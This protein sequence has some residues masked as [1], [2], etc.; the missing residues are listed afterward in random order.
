MS[1]LTSQQR[2]LCYLGGIVL[3]LI[4][5]I[6][7]GM[8]AGETDPGTGRAV[9][10]GT[11]ARL[12]QEYD[13]GDTSLGNVDPAS[14]TMT[15]VLLG[16]RGLA[17]NAL[18]LESMEHQKMKDWAQLRANVDSIVMLQPHF[19]NVWT[20]QSWNLAY[21][22]SVEWDDPRDRYYW[23]KEGAKFSMKGVD[24]NRNYS[25]LYW[26][27]GRIL[28]HKI[29]RADEKRQ[30]R[31]YFRSD[32]DE[33]FEGG[34]DPAVSRFNNREYEDHYLAAKFWYLLANEVELDHGQSLQARVLFRHYP[35]RAAMSY[36]AALQEEGNFGEKT[37]EAWAEA[38]RN[39][40]ESYEGGTVGFG[41]D[42]FYGRAGRYYL[43]ADTED[44]VQALVDE[45]ADRF[46]F[47]QKKDMIR[48]SR[49]M[50]QYDYWRTRSQA[51]SEGLAEGAHRDFYE[52]AQLYKAAKNS[53]AKQ[54]IIAGLQKFEDLLARYP[55]LA[56]DDTI[57]EECMMAY[58]YLRS[59]HELDNEPMPAD[60]PLRRQNPRPQYPAESLLER[61]AWRIPHLETRF[62]MDSQAE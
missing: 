35:A 50:V 44:E 4:P 45:D 52:G 53:E 30:F 19:M 60:L 39:W 62:R 51:E 34:Q 38:F 43:E 56:H 58:M 26:W 23:I 54:R 49:N 18:W 16:F 37:R 9:G 11:L 27:T 48:G 40:T 13:L 29:G 22:V 15:L 28:D 7:L 1:K 41:L 31:R 32:P 3:L 10:G 6:T 24:R 59:I 42:T 8:P 55:E 5:V 12:R 14:A 57:I 2:K 25:E 46:T 36:P 21:N 33:Q 61:E 47:E 17:A 20:F